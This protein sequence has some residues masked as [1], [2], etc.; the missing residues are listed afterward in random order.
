MY[1]ISET[2]YCS[3]YI[4]SKQYS[5]CIAMTTQNYTP[6][7]CQLLMDEVQMVG[8]VHQELRH[9]LILILILQSLRKLDSIMTH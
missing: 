3:K 9:P 6:L 1:C 2:V 5:N 8:V 7:P 4:V